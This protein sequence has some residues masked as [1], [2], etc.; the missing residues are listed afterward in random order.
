MSSKSRYDS[1]VAELNRLGRELTWEQ[2]FPALEH[3]VAQLRE[4]KQKAITK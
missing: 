1:L 4:I 2:K 3:V